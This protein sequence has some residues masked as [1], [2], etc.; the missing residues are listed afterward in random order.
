MEQEQW[1]RAVNLLERG[2]VHD[3]GAPRKHLT[4]GA[5]PADVVPSF[6]I[7]E[8]E[9]HLQPSHAMLTNMR[10]LRLDFRTWTAAAAIAWASWGC[11]SSGMTSHSPTAS[12]PPEPGAQLNSGTNPAGLLLMAHGGGPEWNDRVSAA[13]D[14][15]RDHMPVSVA[16]GMANPH[17]LQASLDSLHARGVSTAA[18]VRL[19]VS[20][21]SFLHPTEYLFG[22]RAD[23]PARAMVGHRWVDGDQLA[24]LRTDARILLDL[25]GM[26]GSDEAAQIM[27][28]RADAHAP[29][30]SGTGALL[31]A[32]GMGA[33]DENRALLAAMEDAAAAL[34]SNG[35]AEVELATLREDWAAER[36]KAE[37]HIRATVARMGTEHDRVVVIPY[38]V[39]GF[40][41]YATVL[42]GLDYT[43][44]E[45]LLPHELVTQWITG[46]ATSVFCAAGLPSPLGLCDPTMTQTS[47]PAEISG[48]ANPS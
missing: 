24:P 41:P 28:Y 48:R 43:G 18:V 36:V 2:M 39:F 8:N 17:T 16:F 37:E 14:D 4:G 13:V 26:A 1:G 31:I 3:G 30:P 38:R 20:G 10:F 44:T 42:D 5:S 25:E 34:R 22:L 6:A 23:A 19:F 46:R 11:A 47:N 15:L 33:E 27:V 7:Y 12:P 9:S 21:F 29:N 40:G 35:Y 45:G 32:H